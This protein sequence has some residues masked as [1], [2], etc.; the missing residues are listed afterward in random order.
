[1]AQK[2]LRAFLRGGHG[3]FEPCRLRRRRGD[4][5]QHVQQ[6]AGDHGDLL[7]ISSTLRE[8]PSQM[9]DRGAASRLRH[10][11]LNIDRRSLEHP[12]FGNS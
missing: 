11:Q 5:P 1:L 2:L 9:G 8:R 6:V 3:S 10:R 7:R 4:A 12:D